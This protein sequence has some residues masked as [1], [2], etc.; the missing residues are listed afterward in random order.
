MKKAHRFLFFACAVAGALLSGA[1]SS[2]PDVAEVSLLPQPKQVEIGQESFRLPSSCRIGVSDP[3]L[4]NAARLLAG[5]LGPSTGYTFDIVDGPGDIMLKVDT[6][7][8]GLEGAYRLQ[9][10]ASGAVVT[11]ES[12]R[13]VI[14]GIQTLRQLLPDAVE[15]RTKADCSWE[16][17]A[18]SISD[19]PKYEWRGL[20]LDVSRHFY[21]PA[22]VK[23]LL[24][25]M[26]LYKMNKFHWHLTDDQGWRV[27]IKAYPL[28]T[29]KGAWRTF[30][31]HDRSCMRSAQSNP[32]FQLPSDERIK[33]VDGD[34]LYGGFYTQEQIK[35][36]VAYAADRGIDV[37]PEVDMPGHM[38][39]AVSNYKGVSCF[40]ETGWGTTFSSPVCP[41][42]DSALEFCKNVY[43]E[44]FTLFPY[45]YVHIGGDEVEK[46]NWN[47]CPDCQRRIR[48]LGLKSPEELQ[49]W[50][51]HQMEAFFNENGRDMIGWDEILEGGLSKTATV[52]W[53]RSWVGN[54]PNHTTEQGNSIIFTPNSHFYL[55]YQQDQ[56]SVSKIYLY[57]PA[58]ALADSTRSALIRGV[59]G[60]IWCEYIPS[61]ERMQYMV[62]PRAL[63]IAELGW[64]GGGKDWDGF[65]SRMNRQF[66]RLDR[67][68]VN[69]RLPDIVG[70]NDIN[71]FLDKAEVKVSCIDPDA[72]IRYTTD[73]SVPTQES[74]RYE[75]PFEVSE[76]CDVAF[77]A[78]R[79]NGKGDDIFKFR[80]VKDSYAPAVEA[81]PT[82]SGLEATWYE[83]GGES[84]KEIETAP[85]KGTYP[86]SDV[87]IPKEA[88]GRIGLV[89]QG[90]I[91]VP[92]DDIYTFSLNSDDGSI[93]TIDGA[94]VIDNDGAHSPR[95]M[96]G[97]KA[98]AAGLH[99]IEVRYFDH[100]GGCL[101]MQVSGSD[102]Q[103][104]AAGQL[105]MY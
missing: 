88:S 39:A 94:V 69:Y 96:A 36:I 28:L 78:F 98:L 103:E 17:P 64:N 24:D 7:L 73:G 99:R 62:F 14:A 57:E 101:D 5:I 44:I 15:S 82:R 70:D 90:Y 72:D 50:F 16:I 97:Q 45:R 76:T 92:A 68:N 26:S 49:S 53:W 77:R 1:C 58:S 63:A 80:Y 93:L 38:L 55:D 67:L 20:M 65:A 8:Q 22:E 61:R 102:K 11:G 37:V 42:K 31:W 19:A 104:L 48:Q 21:T 30:N 10:D 60:N 59:Q 2:R 95:R 66:D 29:E 35:D 79:S 52:M 4:K 54:A 3:Q 75:G 51:I 91:K 41:G 40:N 84:C 56:H 85:K 25:L 33:V 81:A 105:Y 71:V 86:V 9:V 13:G 27:E 46:T 89:I 18:V 83:Y 23:E 34:T 47:K 100:N 74:A 87:S 6:T 32:D 43:R 12:Y